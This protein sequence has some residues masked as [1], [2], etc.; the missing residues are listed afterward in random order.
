MSAEPGA[1]ARGAQRYAGGLDAAG[2][3]LRSLLGTARSLAS[4]IAP[5]ELAS[6]L[7]AR[8]HATLGFDAVAVNLVDRGGDLVI[9]AAKGTPEVEALRGMVVERAVVDQLLSDAEPWGSLRFVDN[10][11]SRDAHAAAV[12]DDAWHPGDVLLA[13]MLS[14]GG[15]LLG[16]LSVDR[17][18]DGLLPAT[19]RCVMLEVVAAHAASALHRLHV[20][21]ELCDA[22]AA[23]REAVERVPVGVAVLDATLTVVMA[24]AA[25]G[26]TVGKRP[27]DLVGVPVADLLDEAD[28]YELLETCRS[29]GAGREAGDALEHRFAYHDGPAR[30][31]RSSVSAIPADRAHTDADRRKRLLLISCDITEE[32]RARAELGV[33]A[34]RDSLTGLGNRRA[35]FARI[36]RALAR[37][38]DGELVGLVVL[39]VDDLARI[40]DTFGR[41][42]GDAALVRAATQIGSMLRSGEDLYRIG[43]DELAVVCEAL[44]TRHSADALA[45]RL[46]AAASRTPATASALACTLSAG[47]AVGGDGA[48][49]S[50]TAELVSAAYDALEHARRTNGRARRR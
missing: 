29:V 8:A 36:E 23:H 19:A 14:P 28:A 18:R 7:A 40:N 37:R 39:D 30:W 6:A 25:L 33:H 49:C 1:V 45:E 16:I 47:I 2:E 24:N 27:E 3:E 42:A 41:N 38:R 12:R 22:S 31:A 10:A 15:E 50:S 48:P 46:V 5:A 34:T 21:A 9:S 32:R 17:P 35:A 20:V 11:R 13:P 26:R 4:T 43:G 44:R